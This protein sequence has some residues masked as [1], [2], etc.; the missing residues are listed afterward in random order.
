MI[1]SKFMKEFFIISNIYR[2]MSNVLK[3]KLLQNNIPLNETQLTIL[4]LMNDNN[5]ITSE[6]I[7]KTGY[8]NVSSLLFNISGLNNKD[9]IHLKHNEYE[10]QLNC[11]MEVSDNGKQ[12]LNT[13]DKIFRKYKNMDTENLLHLLDEYKKGLET[14]KS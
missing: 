3:E 12:V 1:E 2:T 11:P 8:F 7:L 5:H 4:F 13:I 10:A 14:I 9:Y 6:T